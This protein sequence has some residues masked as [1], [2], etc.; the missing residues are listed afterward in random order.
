M[1]PERPQFLEDFGFKITEEGDQ[2]F[3]EKTHESKATY[4]SGEVRQW[5]GEHSFS[6][7]IA[8]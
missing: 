7:K 5:Q 6:F 2:V 4:K 3:F 1:N 8:P